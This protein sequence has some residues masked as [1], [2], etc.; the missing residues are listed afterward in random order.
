MPELKLPKHP[1]L[2]AYSLEVAPWDYADDCILADACVGPK[3]TRTVAGPHAAADLGVPV[4]NLSDPG[5]HLVVVGLRFDNDQQKYGPIELLLPIEI[6]QHRPPDF[7]A[8]AWKTIAVD[9][10]VVDRTI[11]L[12]HLRARVDHCSPVGSP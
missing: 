9:F 3:I 4:A 10:E 2:H 7:L 12:L 8:I 1:D 5:P 6:D 11:T